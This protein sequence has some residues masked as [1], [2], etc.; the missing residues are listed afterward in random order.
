M[1][2]RI[3]IEPHE[4]KPFGVHEK[5][6]IKRQLAG[7]VTGYDILLSTKIKNLNLLKFALDKNPRLTIKQT[8]K[9]LNCSVRT[10]TR[11]RTI[12]RN[13]YG[14][15][16]K[17]EELVRDKQIRIKKLKEF[18]RKNPEI[19]FTEQFKKLG[20]SERTGRQYLKEMQ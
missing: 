9:L 8:V 10:A 6:T 2:G 11:Y 19:P 5:E 16:D 3:R 4:K 1:G 20:I 14:M 13:K 18:I 15:I 7:E 17:V 12:I